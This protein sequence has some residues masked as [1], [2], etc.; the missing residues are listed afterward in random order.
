[1]ADTR[2]LKRRGDRWSFQIAVPK[3]LQ[4]RY[5]SSVII[6]A[7]G[8]SDL[9]EAKRLRWERVAKVQDV[10]ERL[11]GGSALTSA[12]IEQEAQGAYARAPTSIR[13]HWRSSG[14]C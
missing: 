13:R 11:R 7:L 3:D 10:F 9:D 1:M 12:E 5:G 8:T 4:E 2:Y 14:R 6:E